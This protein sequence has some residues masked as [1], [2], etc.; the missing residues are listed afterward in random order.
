MLLLYMNYLKI[1]DSLQEQ[2]R[3][4]TTDQKNNLQSRFTLYYLLTNLLH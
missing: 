4:E 2:K 1:F 3:L